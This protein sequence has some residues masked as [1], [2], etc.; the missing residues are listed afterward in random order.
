MDEL[1]SLQTSRERTHFAMVDVTN[2]LPDEV[3]GQIPAGIRDAARR[4]GVQLSSNVSFE[5]DMA[6]NRFGN[7][8]LKA[9]SQNLHKGLLHQFWRYC[10]WIQ[11]YNSMLI[12]ITPF[13]S[14][15][16]A[17]KKQTI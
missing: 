17:M 11:D 7:R 1:I 8:G 13:P 3:K 15:V 16:P 9:G 14:Q 10:A 6:V 4:W 2:E 5:F 12:L